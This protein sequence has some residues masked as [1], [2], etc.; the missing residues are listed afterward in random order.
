MWPSFVRHIS[1]EIRKV[2]TNLQWNL[3]IAELDNNICLWF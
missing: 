1:S 2:K 3:Y